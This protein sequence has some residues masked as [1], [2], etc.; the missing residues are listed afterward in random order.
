MIAAGRPHTVGLESDGAP[1]SDLSVAGFPVHEANAGGQIG[2][3]FL[4]A[5]LPAR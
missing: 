2:L 3:F 4:V 1:V 5:T